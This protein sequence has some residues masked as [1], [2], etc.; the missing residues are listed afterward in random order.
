M[1]TL[2]K[3]TLEFKRKHVWTLYFQL[4]APQ[5]KGF[6]RIFRGGVGMIKEQ[7]LVDA[8]RMC[9]TTIMKKTSPKK[10]EK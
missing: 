4:T 6:N 8:Y 3:L 10:G 9:R 2:E 1:E 5:K 7:Y